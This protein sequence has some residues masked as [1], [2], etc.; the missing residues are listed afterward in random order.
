LTRV[1]VDK[2]AELVAT[3]DLA[4]R[5]PLPSLVEFGGPEFEG[6]MREGFQKPLRLATEL[7][8]EHDGRDTP[9]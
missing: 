8:G 7:G 9:V 5:R 2:T 3:A 6:A 1:F 4:F